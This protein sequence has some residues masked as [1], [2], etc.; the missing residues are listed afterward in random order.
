MSRSGQTEQLRLKAIAAVTGG[1][2]H[3]HDKGQLIYV[4]EG[5]V[6]LETS[7][8][9]WIAPK[10][11][12][13]WVPPGIS[14]AARS[15]GDFGGW[16]LLT[17]A[18]MTERLPAEPCV[19][20]ASE[21]LVAALR[22]LSTLSAD[23]HR[24]HGLL[25]EIVA[26]DLAQAPVE[27][28][29]ITLP[30]E[31]RLRRWALGFLEKPNMKV[32]IDAVASEVNMSRRSFTRQFQ[33]QTGVSFSDWKRT[34]IVNHVLEQMVA[35]RQVSE[36]AFDVGYESVS[37]FIA[38]FKSVKGLPPQALLVGHRSTISNRR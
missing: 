10:G 38:M 16:M 4:D 2:P 18:A 24:L 5:L 25:M 36:L 22:R 37:A 23:D 6:G 13:A 19:L 35:G 29:G 26:F 34:A 33:Q 17:T 14:H 15:M 1:R 30:T 20:S 32:A 27:P 21:L 7:Q 11:R 12:L 31:E 28:F 8:G 9:V 3:S